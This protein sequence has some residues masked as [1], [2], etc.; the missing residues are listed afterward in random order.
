MSFFPTFNDEGE[1]ISLATKLLAFYFVLMPLDSINI[2]NMGSLL[3]VVAVFPIFIILFVNKKS[4]LHISGMVIWTIIYTLTL[5][6]S[7]FYSISFSDS[8]SGTRRILINVILILCVGGIYDEYNKREYDYLIKAL[9]I[10]GVANVILTFMNPDSTNVYGR[11]TLSM[12][13]STQ[14]MNYINGYMFFALA[15]FVKKL[16]KDRKLYSLLPIFVMLV[17]TL[18]TG[19]RGALLAVIAIVLSSVTYIFIIDKNI[20]PGTALVT[21]IVALLL[22]RYY[23]NIL[24]LISPQV[25]ERFTKAFIQNYKGVNRTDLWLYILGQF[26]DSSFLRQIFGYGTGTVYI[27]N[28]FTHQVAHNLWLDHLIGNGIVG[29]FIFAGMQICFLREAFKS[30]DV[31]LISTYIGLLTMCLTLSLVSYKPIWNCM[32]MIMIASRV[33]MKKGAAVGSQV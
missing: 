19:S 24:M 9:V 21:V 32:M 27:V 2:L 1:E 31:V 23:K 4:H 22:L 14:D 25:A 15:F 6:V 30:K 20:K 3:K 8:L 11:L 26:K 16:I 12:A 18:K 10:G 13:G 29:L 28:E 7:C 17:F 33:D 5:A